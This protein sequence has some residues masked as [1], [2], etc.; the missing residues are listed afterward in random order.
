MI[1]NSP[2]PLP[3]K[4]IEVNLPQSFLHLLYLLLHL[5]QLIY[6]V[7]PDLIDLIIRSTKLLIICVQLEDLMR[8]QHQFLK[9]IGLYVKIGED[10]FDIFHWDLLPILTEIGLQF[11]VLSEQFFLFEPNKLLNQLELLMQEAVVEPNGLDSDLLEM[12]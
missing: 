11:I 5:N 12:G 1:P 4:V 8:L 2:R 7:I 6:K 9:V 3:P 10:C